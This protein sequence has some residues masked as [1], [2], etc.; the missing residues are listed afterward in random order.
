MFKIEESIKKINS[1][2]KKL[3]LSLKKEILKEPNFQFNNDKISSDIVTFR[4]VK[5]N[6]DEHFARSKSIL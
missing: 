5:I 3:Q 4:D 2:N 1:K 6:C